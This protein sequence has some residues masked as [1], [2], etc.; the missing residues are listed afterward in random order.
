MRGFTRSEKPTC[1]VEREERWT[2]NWVQRNEEHKKFNWPQYQLQKLNTVLLPDL[3][4]DNQ[5]HCC[6][7]D[8]HPVQGV[9][10][11][12]IDHFKPKSIYPDLAFR[13][14]NLFYCCSACQEEKL[15]QFEEGLIKPDFPGFSFEKYFH[16]NAKTGE[17]EPNSIATEEVRGKAEVTIRIM[18]LNEKGRPT[19]RLKMLRL[20]FAQFNA[21]GVDIDDLPYRFIFAL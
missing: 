17:I 18:G 1:L 10:S 14:E 8:A 9:S 21:G 16:F 12:T 6:Y 11:D 5:F 2:A 19:T 3:Q 15:E 13:W 20:H 7:C 4:S